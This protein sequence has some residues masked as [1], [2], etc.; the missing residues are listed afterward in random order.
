MDHLLTL[1]IASVIVGP[2]QA[3]THKPPPP[4]SHLPTR[5]PAWSWNL[6]MACNIRKMGNDYLP[7][8]PFPAYPVLYYQIITI[9]G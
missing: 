4:R 7:M 3:G 1:R 9:Y 8:S 2:P 5:D 6:A